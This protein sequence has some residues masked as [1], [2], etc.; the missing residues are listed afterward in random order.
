VCVLHKRFA[1]WRMND[2]SEWFYGPGVQQ[3]IEFVTALS[4]EMVQAH[5]EGEW[6]PPPIWGFPDWT[7]DERK[8]LGA[9]VEP[10]IPEAPRRAES[11]DVDPMVPAEYNFVPTLRSRVRRQMIGANQQN[12][13]PC[14]Q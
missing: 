10:T 8:Y 6:K 13:A 14:T 5:T 12:H 1:E 4:V 2:H 3:V 7:D 11:V 9:Q